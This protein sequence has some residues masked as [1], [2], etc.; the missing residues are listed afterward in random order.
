MN[1]DVSYLIQWCII[2]LLSSVKPQYD[3]WRT[4]VS[5]Y[6]AEDPLGWLYLGATE[7][8][9]KNRMREEGVEMELFDDIYFALCWEVREQNMNL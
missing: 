3:T 7:L 5:S 4:T 9:I 2:D 6:P 8:L 1:E